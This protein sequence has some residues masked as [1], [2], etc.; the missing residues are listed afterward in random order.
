MGKH[1]AMPRTAPYHKELYLVPNIK[2][3]EIEKPGVG[4]NE[5]ILALKSTNN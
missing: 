4:I 3:A 5:N 1:P 2:R